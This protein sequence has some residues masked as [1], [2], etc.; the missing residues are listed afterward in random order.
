[1]QRAKILLSISG[2]VCF[3]VGAFAIKNK[4]LFTGY[5][6]C[7]TG[8]HIGRYIEEYTTVRKGVD[9]G[10]TLTCC[11]GLFGPFSSAT[12]YYVTVKA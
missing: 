1:M 4:H 3:V 6:S 10:V 9:L 7:F 12:T 11:V 5:Y 8:A 2:L